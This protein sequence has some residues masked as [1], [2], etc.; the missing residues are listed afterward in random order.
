VPLLPEPP[1]LVLRQAAL[2]EQG[3]VEVEMTRVVD[4]LLGAHPVVHEVRE[5]LGVALGLHRAAHVPEDGPEG[6]LARGEARD[7][8]VHRALAGGEPIRVVL[9]EAEGE[10]PVLEADAGAGGYHAAAEAHVEA[11]DKRAAVP[12][13]VH[14]AQV[15]RVLA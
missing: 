2:D 14:G 1:D 6:A 8:R 3:A 15:R 7:D 12:L 5:D 13:G 11:V 10:A 4:S 9:V